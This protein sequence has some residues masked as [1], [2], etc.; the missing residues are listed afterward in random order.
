MKDEIEDS[1]MACQEI[2][3]SVAELQEKVQYLDKMLCAE[4]EATEK[5]SRIANNYRMALLSFLDN[6][7]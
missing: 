7:F 6:K 3:P 5:Q 4:R 2:K 1:T